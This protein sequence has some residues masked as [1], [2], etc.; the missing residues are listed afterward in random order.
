[1]ETN[2]IMIVFFFMGHTI[3]KIWRLLI[4][5]YPRD[6]SPSRNKSATGARKIESLR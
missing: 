3:R 1:M 4:Q 2:E 5:V 6:I